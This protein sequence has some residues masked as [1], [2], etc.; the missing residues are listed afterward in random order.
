MYVKY[1]LDFFEG[2]LDIGGIRKVFFFVEFIF[3]RGICL[4]N[5][6]KYKRKFQEVKSDD[7]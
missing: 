7:K 4:I 2:I 5:K 1:L 6:L 3:Y